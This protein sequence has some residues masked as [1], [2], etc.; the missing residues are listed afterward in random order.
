MDQTL[1]HYSFLPWVRQGLGNQITEQDTL[2][3]GVPTNPVLE[4]P[5]VIVSAKVKAVDSAGGTHSPDAN[6]KTSKNSRSG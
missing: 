4:R 6:L 3:N 1:A 5:E 2:G